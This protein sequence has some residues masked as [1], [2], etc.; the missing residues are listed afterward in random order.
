MTTG[1]SL[2]I[3]RQIVD[4]IRAAIATGKLNVGDALPSVR[5][6]AGELFLNPNTVAKAYAV[7]VRDGIINSQQGIGY[8]VAARRDIYTRRERQ[9]RLEEV[10]DPFLAAALTLGF[11]ADQIV[12]EVQE[13]LTKLSQPPA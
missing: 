8:F 9:R 6:L 5:S 7:L 12:I 2:P 11:D 13:R 4:Q 1:S 10:L 3:Y